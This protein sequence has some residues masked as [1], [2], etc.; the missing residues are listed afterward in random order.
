MKPKF[1][2]DGLTRRVWL[3]VDWKGE[4]PVI[5]TPDGHR[6]TLDGDWEPH[7]GPDWRD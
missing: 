1:I 4:L 5:E 6:I 3:V 7:A 2:Y